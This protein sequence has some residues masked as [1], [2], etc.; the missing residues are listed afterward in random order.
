MSQKPDILHLD[1][2]KPVQPD[3]F[4]VVISHTTRQQRNTHT[5]HHGGELQQGIIAM[6]SNRDLRKKT[7]LD[8]LKSLLDIGPRDS[9]ALLRIPDRIMRLQI[10]AAGIG[11]HR[12]SA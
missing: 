6:C 11:R 4:R 3:Q 7:A 1:G 8:L 5:R 9:A 10:A 2:C 12:E